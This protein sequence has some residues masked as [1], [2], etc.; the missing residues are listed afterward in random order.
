MS[1]PLRWILIAAVWLLAACIIWSE[2]SNLGRD[3]EAPH[4]FLDPVAINSESD[5]VYREEVINLDQGLPMV[6]VASL[7]EM[8]DGLLAAVWYGGNSECAPDVKIYFSEKEAQFPWVSPR[9]IMTREQAEKD[10]GRPVKSLGNSVLLPGPGGSLRLLFDTIAMGRWSGS[11]LN[12]SLS[13]D[14]GATWAPSERLTL[15][16]FF[17]FSELVRNRPVGL[18]S[19]GWCVPIYQEFLG[20]FPELLWLRER[21]GKLIAEKSRIAGGCSSFQPSIIPLGEESAVVL[22]RDYTDERKIF[23]TTTENAGRS[24]KVRSASTLPNPDSGI[25][26]LKLSDGRLLV[27]FNNSSKDRSNLSLAFSDD[28]G[29]SWKELATL[30]SQSGST[31]SYPYLMRSSDGLIHMAYTWRSKAIKMVSFNEAWI[32]SREARSIVP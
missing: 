26:G 25:S 31:F 23:L 24:W 29:K 5:V 18:H 11:Q 13:K 6:H 1:L 30:E 32:R 27:A 21:N 4:L 17:N 16:P 8:S 9:A 22:L 20:K 28:Q 14:G 12:S 15:S 19:G 10:L 3:A 7:T 2:R